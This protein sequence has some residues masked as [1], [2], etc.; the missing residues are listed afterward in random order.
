MRQFEA[1]LV[2]KETIAPAWWQ[3]VFE[4]PD[5]LLPTQPGQFFLLRCGDRFTCY[6]RRAIFPQ[7]IDDTRLSLLLRPATDPGLS[8]LLARQTGDR[9]DFI[10]PLGVGFERLTGA[11][12][13]LLVSDNQMI[14]PL[15]G[16]MEQA[17]V[18]G[19]SVTLALEGIRANAIYPVATLPPAVEF[20]AATLDGS[21]GYRGVITDLLPRYLQWAD[22][23]CAVGSINLYKVLKKQVADIRFGLP[24]GF[25]YGLLTH[26]PLICGVGA[27]VGCAVST[28]QGISL[29]CTD[30]PVFDL[31]GLSI[32]ES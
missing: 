1:T 6:L 29:A 13:L 9:L 23:V 4:T 31:A 11:G 27:C 26:L 20:Q 8:W 10:G 30:G 28:G 19:W 12:N 2:Q 17:I 5:S 25:S 18:A 21:L 14:S 22:M 16:Q 3:L 24:L 32:G 15:L 7:P